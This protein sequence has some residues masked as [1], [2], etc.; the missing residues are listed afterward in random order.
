MNEEPIIIIV[1][2]FFSMELCNLTDLPET[3]IP[4]Q[5]QENWATSLAKVKKLCML[6]WVNF[7]CPKEISISEPS[8]LMVSTKT[9]RT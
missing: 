1:F 5:L 8:F 9:V 4:S 2:R 6:M 7:L 3:K